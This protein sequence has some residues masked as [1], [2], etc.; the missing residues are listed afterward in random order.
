MRVR[1]FSDGTTH[2]HLR[3]VRPFIF[4]FS[5]SVFG[6]LLTAAG[7]GE[8]LHGPGKQ[9]EDLGIGLMTLIPGLL[10]V[11]QVFW[12]AFGGERIVVTPSALVRKTGRLRSAEAMLL[13]D[14]STFVVTGEGEEVRL[15]VQ[16]G[17]RR[18]QLL[19]KLGFTE[20]DLRWLAKRLRS[21]I[22]FARST[23]R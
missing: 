6:L 10:C 11:R 20:P 4:P 5:L 12:Y 2:L 21:A 8:L 13:A 18:V 7:L 1:T 19:N 17:R 23:S 16:L 14:V 9:Y 15:D 3:P 22:D